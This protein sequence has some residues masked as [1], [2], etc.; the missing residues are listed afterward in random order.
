MAGGYRMP[1]GDLANSLG[2]FPTL[3][4]DD[5]ME[6]WLLFLRSINEHMDGQSYF[7][8]LFIVLIAAV[9]LMVLNVKIARCISAGRDEEA[10]QR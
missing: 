4:T 3:L 6:Q 1:A 9:A 2:Y 7:L 10:G 8:V 5:G